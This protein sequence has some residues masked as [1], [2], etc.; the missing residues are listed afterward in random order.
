MAVPPLSSSRLR[1]AVQQGREGRCSVNGDFS[2]V[3]LGGWGGGERA[4]VL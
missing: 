4:D 3:C 2:G 1:P